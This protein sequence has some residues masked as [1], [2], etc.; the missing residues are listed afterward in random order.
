MGVLERFGHRTAPAY[1][2]IW[3]HSENIVP[4]Y[5]PGKKYS[6]EVKTFF[7]LYLL[8]LSSLKDTR[9]IYISGNLIIKVVPLEPVVTSIVA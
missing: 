5:F 4:L 7:K 8:A 2:L 3:K 1:G 9:H 6:Q